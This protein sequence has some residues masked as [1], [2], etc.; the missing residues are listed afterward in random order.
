MLGSGPPTPPTRL[1]TGPSTP[2]GLKVMEVRLDHLQWLVPHDGWDDAELAADP[3]TFKRDREPK[4][5]HDT[6]EIAANHT[7]GTVLCTFTPGLLDEHAAA[8]SAEPAC[9]H[10][11]PQAHPDDDVDYLGSTG[12]THVRPSLAVLGPRVVLEGGPGA[13]GVGGGPLDKAGDRDPTGVLEL[14]GLARGRNAHAELKL[15]VQGRT[16]GQ[17]VQQA[18]PGCMMGTEHGRHLPQGPLE[19]WWPRVRKAKCS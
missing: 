19:P 14:V 13:Y 16:Q 15:Q 9:F 6:H 1:P 12:Q 3:K 5:A 8:P 7:R 2:A 4:T 10:V 11:G 18:G 17:Y